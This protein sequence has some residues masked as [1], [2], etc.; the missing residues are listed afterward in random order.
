MEPTLFEATVEATTDDARIRCIGDLNGRAD[1]AMDE[2]YAAAAAAG[3]VRMTLDFTACGY[4]NSTG[5]ALIVRLLT[6][7]RADGRSVRAV[8]LTEHYRQ[9]FEITRLSD[10]MAITDDEPAGAPTVAATTGGA[11]A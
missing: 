10:Y 5:I 1:A 2:A 7:A 8:G 3:A 11:S 4:I 6:S 9:I